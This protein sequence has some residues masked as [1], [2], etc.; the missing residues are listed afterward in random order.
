MRTSLRMIVLTA[1]VFVFGQSVVPQTIFD[2]VDNGDTERIKVLIAENPEC[3]NQRL[4]SGLTPLLKAAS[5]GQMDI[6]KLLIEKGADIHAVDNSQGTALH[7]A[8]YHGHSDLIRLFI[9][10]GIGANVEDNAGYTPILWAIFGKKTNTIDEL[11][12]HGADLNPPM[13]IG[14]SVLHFAA[15]SS[16]REVIEYLL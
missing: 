1:A 14:R 8:A 2:A 13:R 7:C 10:S 9:E 16:D 3:I 6:C 15:A 5:N 4:E 11:I 12:K